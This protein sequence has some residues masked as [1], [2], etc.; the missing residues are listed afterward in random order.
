LVVNSLIS[1]TPTLSQNTNGINH[2]VDVIELLAPFWLLAESV[3]C[4]GSLI[5]RAQHARLASRA[6]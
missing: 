5:G 2:H 6:D 4:Y 3:Q 1:L